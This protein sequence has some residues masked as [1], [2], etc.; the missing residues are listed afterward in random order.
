MGHETGVAD[1]DNLISEKGP[2]EIAKLLIAARQKFLANLEAMCPDDRD[3][4]PT[5][6][7]GAEYK[8]KMEEEM[9][10]AAE[11]AALT[12]AGESEAADCEESEDED[13]EKEPQ[14]KK[15]KTS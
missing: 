10:A 6:M 7:K 1:L 4:V 3:D 13:G 2:N 15:Q 12:E 5:E 14:P 8:Q 11:A 9:A